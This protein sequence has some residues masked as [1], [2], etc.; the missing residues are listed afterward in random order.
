ML[1]AVIAS[2]NAFQWKVEFSIVLLVATLAVRST[3]RVKRFRLDSQDARLLGKSAITL[4]FNGTEG[5]V[6]VGDSDWPARLPHGMAEPAPGTI[7]H[8]EAVE[9]IILIVRPDDYQHVERSQTKLNLLPEKTVSTRK[10]P[11]GVV[12]GGAPTTIAHDG[13]HR[14]TIAAEEVLT[15][16]TEQQLRTSADVAPPTQGK[17]LNVSGTKPIHAFISYAHKDEMLRV[18]LD[19]HLK[20]LCATG[21]L[22][23]WHD[24]SIVPGEKWEGEIDR[25][26]LGADLVLLLLSPDFIGS[27]YCLHEMEIALQCEASG[28]T[29]VVPIILRPCGW[30]HLPVHGNQALPNNGKPIADKGHDQSH[31]DAAWVEVEEGLRRILKS[32]RSECSSRE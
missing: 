15:T 32:I 1:I 26:L 20:P 18:E 2:G 10:N 7:L 6:R 31:R 13:E 19:T 22:D 3:V 8:V 16:N 5:R 23:A 4:S 11:R 25:K 9:G 14:F 12:R 27:D 21:E 29:R 17:T 24:R 30:T 28:Q